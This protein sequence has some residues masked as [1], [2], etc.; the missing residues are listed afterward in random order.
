MEKFNIKNRRYLGNKY[1]L[2]SFIEKVIN[3]NCK[4]IKIVA[5]IFSG[6]GSFSTLFKNKILIT[7]DILYSNYLCN[8]AWFGVDKVRFDLIEK[9][10][11]RIN[12]YNIIEKNYM[13]DNFSNTYFDK[14]GCSKINYARSYIEEL[15][16]EKNINQRERATLITSLIYAMDRVANTC[17]HYDAYIKDNKTFDDIVLKMPDIDNENN[18][19]NKCYN[20]DSNEL[21][22]QIKPDL[23]YIDPPYN[24]RQYCDAY[25]LLENIA[26]W[27]KPTVYGIAKKMNRD[28]LKSKYCTNEAETAFKELIY[29]IDSKY[30]V[31]S[32]NSTANKL[33][34]RSNARISDE[35]ICDVLKEKG[36]LKIFS[37]DYK[38]FTTGKTKKINNKER[39]FLCEV[40]K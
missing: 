30:I 2:L 19:K 25:H 31:L 38:A 13:T 33:N 29:N 27:E 18:K 8:L 3:D 26:K 34:E 4:D 35:C 6:T 12:K 16:N 24:S 11:M 1:K 15:Y 22:K 23:I 20:I 7:N 21:V 37:S 17:G 39:L 5:D 36:K 14:K 9:I 32:Y 28:N 40:D 10:V